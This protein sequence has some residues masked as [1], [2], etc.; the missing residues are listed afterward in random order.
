MRIDEV[1][2]GTEYT[3]QHH[4]R[5][6]YRAE[7]IE[8]IDQPRYSGWGLATSQTVKVRMVLVTQLDPDTGEPQDIDGTGRTTK[9]VYAR[10]L[11]EKWADYAERIAKRDAENAEWEDVA[12]RLIDAVDRA[13]GTWNAP[14]LERPRIQKISWGLGGWSVALRRKED[15]EALIDALTKAAE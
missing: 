2:I 1:E 9:Y 5:S 15:V 7:A 12:D 8:K 11:N 4:G 14:N 3:H 10:D 13:I 6:R